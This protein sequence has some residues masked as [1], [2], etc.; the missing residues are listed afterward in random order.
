MMMQAIE[1]DN[2]PKAVGPYSQ[3]VSANGM[4]YCSG[5]IAI[6]PASGSLV[7]GDTEAQAHQVMKNLSAV[8]SAAG[9]DISRIIKASIFLKDLNDFDCVNKVYASYLDAP[10]PARVTVEASKL[11]LG[12]LV[13]IDAVAQLIPVHTDN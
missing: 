2:A 4:V 10:Y 12:A 5:Q 6:D 13:E 8:L 9:S 11:P 7:E 1:T 3:A